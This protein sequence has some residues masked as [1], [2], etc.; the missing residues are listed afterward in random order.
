VNARRRNQAPTSLCTSATAEPGPTWSGVDPRGD[1][2]VG[3]SIGHLTNPERTEP[4]D[5]SSVIGSAQYNRTLTD[6]N[7]SAILVASRKW[8][9]H[10]VTSSFLLE[11]DWTVREKNHLFIRIEAL[12]KHGLFLDPDPRHHEVY[13]VGSAGVGYTRDLF[14]VAD[15]SLGLEGEGQLFAV[16]EALHEAYGALPWGVYGFV[17]IRPREM[18]DSH[19]YCPFHLSV[20]WRPMEPIEGI[21]TL[22]RNLRQLCCQKRQSLSGTDNKGMARVMTAR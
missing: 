16:P 18:M 13:P 11:A 20:S 21:Q 14:T 6:A 8:E 7:V 12:E 5:V 4:G 1:D 9:K 22:G 3:L 2:V 17:R 10:G 15:L 19:N